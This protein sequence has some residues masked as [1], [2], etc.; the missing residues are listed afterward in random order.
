LSER[1]ALA[2]DLDDSGVY[3]SSDHTSFKTKLIPILFFFSGLHGDY[4]RPTD[5][6]EKIDAPSTAKLLNL[7]SEFI[8]SVANRTAA[9]RLAESEGSARL[10]LTSAGSSF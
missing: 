9:S 1:Y 3:G 7:L 2:L 4:H 8:L 5:T 10:D 6:W